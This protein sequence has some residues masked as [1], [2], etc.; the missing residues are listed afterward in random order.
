MAENYPANHGIVQRSGKKSKGRGR[1][2]KKK[3]PDYR[4]F[5]GRRG[6]G[7]YSRFY[8]IAGTSVKIDAPRTQV[9]ESAFA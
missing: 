4:D 2:K 7:R 9:F 6:Q 1:V 5:M 3:A 8:M